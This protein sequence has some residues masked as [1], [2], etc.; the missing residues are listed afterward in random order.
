MPGISVN[1]ACLRHRDFM[2]QIFYTNTN[3]N[4]GANMGQWAYLERTRDNIGEILCADNRLIF[5]FGAQLKS[6]SEI[7]FYENRARNLLRMDEEKISAL[8]GCIFDLIDTRAYEK[9][10]HEI[11]RKNVCMEISRAFSI[12]KLL[13]AYVPRRRVFD[14]G[15]GCGIINYVYRHNKLELADI[16]SCDQIEFSRQ[17]FTDLHR[18]MNEN[19]KK[20][21]FG[22]EIFS[23]EFD[24]E[25]VL[26]FRWSF[27]EFDENSKIRVLSLVDK[28]KFRHIVICGNKHSN[29]K[30]D[31]DL[32][33]VSKNYK[34]TFAGHRPFDHGFIRIYEL[35]KKRWNALFLLLSTASCIPFMKNRGMQFLIKNSV[36]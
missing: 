6:S 28:Y 1:I 22:E 10:D 2:Y 15:A 14:M 21:L 16:I 11:I 8:E 7:R 35:Q 5:W 27:D 19:S 25:D 12:L 23:Y 31:I 18:E 36:Q 34:P 17:S 3:S 20:Y 24:A 29:Q 9:K 33:L 30:T 32:E 13:E 4:Y 26:L